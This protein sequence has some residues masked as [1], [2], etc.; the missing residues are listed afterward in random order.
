[1]IVTF[2]NFSF[3]NTCFITR[4]WKL[5]SHKAE[6]CANLAALLGSELCNSFPYF[7]VLALL[8]QFLSTVSFTSRKHSTTFSVVS[9][10]SSYIPVRFQIFLFHYH[11][12][13]FSLHYL[14]T[15]VNLTSFSFLVDIIHLLVSSF[16]VPISCFP[17]KTAF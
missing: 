15:V 8:L 12:Q 13:L 3:G 14:G 10:F 6:F 4:F 9:L 5:G 7:S 2:L 11:L 1:M 17:S 16:Y